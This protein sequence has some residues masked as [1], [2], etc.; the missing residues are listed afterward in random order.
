M[1][2][3][4]HNDLRP[5]LSVIA[6]PKDTTRDGMAE[7]LAQTAGMDA[8]TLRLR[9]G[10]APPSIIGQV[11]PE[12]AARSIKAITER[13]GD[14]FAVTLDEL[15]SLGPAYRVKSMSIA[16]NVLGVELWEGVTTAIRFQDVR[17]LVLGMLKERSRD[18][19]GSSRS[20]RLRSWTH[21]GSSAA[22]GAAMLG[23]VGLAGYFGAGYLACGSS[24]TA[25]TGATTQT[26]NKL[27]IHDRH[28][29]IYE[30]EGR[31]FDFNILGEMKQYSDKANMEQL[32]E[33]LS[34]LAPDEIVDPY[35]P[36]WK[37]PPG[38]HRLRIRGET[39]DADRAFS[40]YS[41]WVAH[42]YR[43]MTEQPGARF[44]I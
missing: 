37:P 31:R 27:H 32:C 3:P 35:F 12:A 4:S 11:Q 42:L 40:F 24:G 14:A 15:A 17:L 2:H 36:L 26:R 41:R 19:P 30:V 13:G 28:G 23:A 1:S 38:H 22:A 20:D 44:S 6:W 39:N 29:T 21:R 43:Q 16:N 18:A 33:L 34:H 5:F 10:L 8:A 9:L 25:G 7:L